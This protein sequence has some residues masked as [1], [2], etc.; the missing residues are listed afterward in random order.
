MSSRL[1]LPV[2]NRFRCI[3][4]RIY[5]FSY[6]RLS[7]SRTRSRFRSENGNK[8]RS[9]CFPPVPIF[10]QPSHVEAGVERHGA[11]R[12]A[13]AARQSHCFV[14]GA[15]EDAEGRVRTRRAHGYRRA[16]GHTA[17]VEVDVLPVSGATAMAAS[18]HERVL[19]VVT[20]APC[21]R[22]LQRPLPE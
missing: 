20:A 12:Q 1:K 11:G 9:G 15:V 22:G 17:K 7:R 13:A 21:R 3:F 14:H 16:R 18:E 2:F 4:V 6:I 5:P 8:N 19:S 10:F